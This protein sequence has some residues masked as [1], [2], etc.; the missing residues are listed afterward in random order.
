MCKK[1]CEKFIKKMVWYDISLLKGAVFFFTLF[2]VTVWPWFNTLV[3][4]IHWGWFLVL[5]LAF[6]APLWK[7]MLK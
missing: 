5:G 4:K 3:M 1:M 6:G 2:L 7:K